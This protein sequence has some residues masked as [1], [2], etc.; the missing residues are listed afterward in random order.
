MPAGDRTG[1]RG[2]GPMTGRGAGHCAGYGMPGYFNPMP[3]RGRGI[4]WGRGWPWRGWGHGHGWLHG[5]RLPSWGR[6]GHAPAWGMPWSGPYGPH[7][8]ASVPSPDQE[9]EFLRAQAD[10]LQEE[11]AAI[12]TR[13]EEL[14]R[15]A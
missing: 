8:A 6:V 4:G 14:E 2:S 10:W 7:A 15:D 5:Y 11:L 9:V 13:L 12:S 3:G 1:P